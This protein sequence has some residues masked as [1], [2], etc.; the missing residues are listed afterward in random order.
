MIVRLA[1]PQRAGRR[2]GNYGV[3]ITA[4]S[5]ENAARVRFPHSAQGIYRPLWTDA[6]GRIRWFQGI[7]LN[8]RSLIRKSWPSLAA[9]CECR[10]PEHPCPESDDR[11]VWVGQKIVRFRKTTNH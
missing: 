11:A 4:Q 3:R 10:L 8:S 6:G 5:P 1:N 2:L 7:P 9:N